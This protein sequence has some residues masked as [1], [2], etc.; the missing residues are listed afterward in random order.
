MNQPAVGLSRIVDLGQAALTSWRLARHERWDRAELVWRQ[1]QR[2]NA[3]VRHAAA[4]TPFYSRLYGG[5]DIDGPFRLQDLPIVTKGEMMASF[6]DFVT[7]RRL[8]LADLREHLDIINTD[9]GG[10]CLYLD[11]YRVLSTSGSSGLKGVFVFDRAEWN[12][13]LG[14]VLR[15][16]A[17]S[18]QRRWPP[19]RKTAVVGTSRPIHTSYRL[20]LTSRFGFNRVRMFRIRDSLDRLVDQ[21]NAFQPDNLNAFSSIAAL[22]AGEQTAGRLRIRPAMVTT[23][24]EVCTPEM[25]RQIEEAWKVTPFNTYGMTEAGGVLGGDCAYHEGVHVFENLFIVEVVDEAGCEVAPGVEGRRVLLTNLYNRTQPLIRF[26][27]TD[28]ISAKADPCSCGRPYRLFD[29]GAGRSDDIILLP[30][31]KGRQ[32]AVHPSHFRGA[33]YEVPAVREF[34]VRQEAVRLRILAVTGNGPSAEVGDQIVRAVTSRLEEIDAVVPL[35]EAVT[36]ASIERG[37]A[38]MGK[39]KLVVKAA[40][41]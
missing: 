18:G 36:V 41:E 2:L 16:S 35:I 15:R 40:P 32:V 19:G 11:E 5:I 38:T 26:E 29:V 4:H 33:M 30:G 24:L 25:R 8:K 14:V 6:D 23:G 34:Q 37:A 10:D 20:G 13:A 9:E 17:L 21:L 39:L 31:R 27:V 12:T 28:M 22:L 3:L 7:D 1:E